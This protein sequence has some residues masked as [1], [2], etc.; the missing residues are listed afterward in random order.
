MKKV[1][2][3]SV[4]I[5][6]TMTGNG[7]KTLLFVHGSF[8]DQSWWSEQVN[9]FKE[10]YTVVTMDLGGHGQSGVNRN[11]WTVQ[12]FGQDVRA[13][14]KQLELKNVILVGHSLGA[15]AVLEAAVSY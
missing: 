7:D 15:D 5:H 10:H 8:I 1:K 6:Y 11:I 14:I 4:P 9:Y 13:V 3:G 2:S 12:K